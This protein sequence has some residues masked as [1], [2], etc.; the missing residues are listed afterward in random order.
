M[1]KIGSEKQLLTR[2]VGVVRKGEF[3]EFPG[4]SQNRSKF[5]ENPEFSPIF[6]GPYLPSNRGVRLLN[7]G[8]K[9]PEISQNP[10]KIPRISGKIREISFSGGPKSRKIGFPKKV[11]KIGS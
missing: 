8:E 1:A 2:G 5:P 4:I 11:P 3:P 7:K 10:E 9:F 6:R